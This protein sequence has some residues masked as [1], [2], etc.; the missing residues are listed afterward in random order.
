MTQQGNSDRSLYANMPFQ[1]PHRQS[2]TVFSGKPYL[3]TPA[4]A[5]NLAVQHSLMEIFD[6][7]TDIISDE[8]RMMDLESGDPGESPNYQDR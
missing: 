5:D 7:F 1:G 8:L 6:E 3:P 4:T 2:G